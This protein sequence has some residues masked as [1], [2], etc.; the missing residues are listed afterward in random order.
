MFGDVAMLGDESD[1]Q[2][3]LRPEDSEQVFGDVVTVGHESDMRPMHDILVFGNIDAHNI[4][5]KKG[6]PGPQLSEDTDEPSVNPIHTGRTIFGSCY[7]LTLGTETGGG[8]A[9]IQFKQDEPIYDLPTGKVSILGDVARLV[10]YD[11][12]HFQDTKF[13]VA[14]SDKTLRRD[15]VWQGGSITI[16]PECTYTRGIRT[17]WARP[18]R[19]P[20]Q[21][22]PPSTEQSRPSAD[23]TSA[24]LDQNHDSR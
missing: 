22:C 1:M 6:T 5:R 3:M 17:A 23:T 19:R 24:A 21:A 4:V 12:S 8:R 15:G 7:E 11:F 13:P 20:P 14:T 9:S 2:P 16:M 10:I 18:S